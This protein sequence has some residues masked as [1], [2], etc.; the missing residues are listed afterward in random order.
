MYFQFDEYYQCLAVIAV[1][2]NKFINKDCYFYKFTDN[3]TYY[4]KCKNNHVKGKFI[5]IEILCAVLEYVK[6]SHYGIFQPLCIN[7]VGYCIE[8]NCQ[9]THIS[10]EDIP[11]LIKA[12]GKILVL[13]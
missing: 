4:S 13:K 1:H 2:V 12:S 8:P 7:F 11:I 10:V 6:T 9:F 5:P 3:C